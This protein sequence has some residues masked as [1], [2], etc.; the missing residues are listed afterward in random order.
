MSIAQAQQRGVLIIDALHHTELC[1]SFIFAAVLHLSPPRSLANVYHS[2]T[3]L[4][5]VA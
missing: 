1:A 5:L 2:P 4:H 3:A